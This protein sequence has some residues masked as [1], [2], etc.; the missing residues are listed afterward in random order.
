MDLD[1]GKFELKSTSDLPNELSL[2]LFKHVSAKIIEN[3]IE[4]ITNRYY[5]KGYI[6]PCLK[7]FFDKKRPT[8]VND[9]EQ[10]NNLTKWGENILESSKKVISAMKDSTL[11]LQGPP[12]SGKTY[13]CARVIA[14]LIKKGKKIGIASNSH[15]AIN[16]VIEELILVMDDQKIDGNVAKVDRTS[17]E[18]K[19]YEIAFVFSENSG[20]EMSHFAGPRLGPR[21]VAPG[22]GMSHLAAVCRNRPMGPPQLAHRNRPEPAGTDRNWPEPTGTYRNRP[23]PTGTGRKPVQKMQKKTK[24]C[25][26]SKNIWK[27][28]RK[29]PN[30]EIAFT[31]AT[32]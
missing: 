3:S 5:Q 25:K 21:Y 27:K 22:R 1:A 4:S 11:C 17:E 30:F 8:L 19:L 7:T 10:K 28:I 14:D 23:E 6:K 24:K 2:I 15:K 9:S 32:G 13:V 29:F 20:R 26:K 16:N 18:E 12:G 31:C